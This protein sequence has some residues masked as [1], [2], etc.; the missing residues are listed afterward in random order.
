MD[1]AA[2]VAEFVGLCRRTQRGPLTPEEQ[3][4]YRELKRALLAA[5]TQQQPQGE[6]LPE[7]KL[8]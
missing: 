7:L 1:V 2:L 6:H 5:Q 3:E 4:R 8:D